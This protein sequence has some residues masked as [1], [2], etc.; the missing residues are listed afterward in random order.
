MTTP[1]PSPVPVPSPSQPHGALAWLELHVVPGLREA[2]AGAEKARAALPAVE[3]FLPKL[4]EL[5]KAQPS[6]AAALAPLIAE[7]EQILEVI[8]AL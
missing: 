1:A 2:L 6:L 8:S 3:A 7:A 5:A 4:A